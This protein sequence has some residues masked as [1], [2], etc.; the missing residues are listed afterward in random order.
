MASTTARRDEVSE[1][2][3]RLRAWLA[4]NKQDAALLE[5]TAN[6]AW[7]TGGAETAIN[8]AADRGPVAL[9]VTAE[10]AYAVSDAVE[11]PRLEREEG[12]TDLGF[13]IVA[14]PWYRRGAFVADMRERLHVGDDNDDN[15]NNSEDSNSLA[16]QLQQLRTTLH[17][18]EVER[19]RQACLLAA[20]ALRDVIARVS[21]GMTELEVAGMI[22]QASR[23]RGGIAVVNLVGSDERIAAYRHPLPTEKRIGRYAMLVLCLRRKGLIAASTRLVH[24]GAL[25]DD[26]ERRARAVAMVDARMIASTQAGR[27]L[28]QQWQLAA[29]AYRDAGFPE[30][31]EEHHQGGSIGYLTRERLAIP[32]DT[33]PMEVSQAFA[34]NPSVRGVKSEDTVLLTADGPEVLTG[35]PEWPIWD[36]ILDGQPWQRPAILVR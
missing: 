9:V 7:L 23:T 1:K 36:V 5:Q 21:P 31:I 33:T 32:G 18:N 4:A 34:W 14:E 27:T 26:L 16:R 29:E 11:R 25:P 28:E 6:V 12:L 3:T 13:E 8:I 24:F 30:A 10:R 20:D 17:P 35:M 2:L 19:L 22:A 15:D